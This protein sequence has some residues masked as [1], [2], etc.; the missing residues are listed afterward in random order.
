MSQQPIADDVMTPTLAGL[1]SGFEFLNWTD[2]RYS[3][4]D[5]TGPLRPGLWGVYPSYMF[6]SVKVVT[7]RGQTA[8]IVGCQWI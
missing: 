1:N 3:D 8:S 6:Q 5:I 2:R 4:E 7:C